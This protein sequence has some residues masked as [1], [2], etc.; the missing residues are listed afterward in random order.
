[1][2]FISTSLLVFAPHARRSETLI[3][4]TTDLH[5]VE[6]SGSRCGLEG[7]RRAI[8]PDEKALFG[9]DKLNIARSEIPGVISATGRRWRVFR[10]R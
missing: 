4:I 7:R 6:G 8:S 9:I 1:M 3:E 2:S 5:V 10:P